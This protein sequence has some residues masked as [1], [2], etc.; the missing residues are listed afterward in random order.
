MVVLLVGGHGLDGEGDVV[1]V[2]L[3][4]GGHGLDGE[5]DVVAEVLLGVT[6]RWPWS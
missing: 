3:L 2:V 4:V 1:A 5:G 6:G